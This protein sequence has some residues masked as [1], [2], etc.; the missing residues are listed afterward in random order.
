[1]NK[2]NL[3]KLKTLLAQK[4]ELDIMYN[5][6]K[7]KFDEENFELINRV[8]ET[9][10]SINYCKDVAREN[11]IAGYEQDK[12]KKRLGGIGIRVTKNLIYDEDIAMDWAKTN[13]PIAV[14][15][16]LDKKTF[17][18]FAKENP[19]EFVKIKENPVVTFPSKLV[20]ENE[21]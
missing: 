20:I 16:V 1:M 9:S 19:V 21:N 2:E 5:E 14:K 15:Q 13:M 8:K 6:K 18:K 3:L 10:E 12:E 4:E 11:A 17:D 7:Q